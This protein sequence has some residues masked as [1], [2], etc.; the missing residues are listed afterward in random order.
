MAK[1]VVKDRV[2]YGAA[3][4]KT[5]EAGETIELEEDVAA[6]LLAA[7]VIAAPAKEGKA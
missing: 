5:A 3:K 7:G 1:F 6:P 4:P 2:K